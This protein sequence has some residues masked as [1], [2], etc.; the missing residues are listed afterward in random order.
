MFLKK[1]QKDVLKEYLPSSIFFFLEFKNNVADEV[2]KYALGSR[3]G[4]A[5]WVAEIGTGVRSILGVHSKLNQ[6]VG[7]RLDL[8]RRALSLDPA[9]IPKY[10]G[11][12]RIRGTGE[13]RPQRC[14]VCTPVSPSSALPLNLSPHTVALLC[15]RFLAYLPMSVSLS[16]CPACSAGIDPAGLQGG[17]W[18]PAWL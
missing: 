17:P 5:V 16:P 11:N 1:C 10:L 7:W 14:R 3:K 4:V 8:R 2:L 6:E 9:E 18:V 15:P 12:L 13:R